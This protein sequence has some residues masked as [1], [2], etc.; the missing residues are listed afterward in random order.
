VRTP[1]SPVRERERGR[2]RDKE[3]EE[4]RERESEKEGKRERERER[5]RICPKLLFLFLNGMTGAL[6]PFSYLV[7]NIIIASTSIRWFQDN[8]GFLNICFCFFVQTVNC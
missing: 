4:G 8:F 2:E 3:R 7:H 5:C 6:A 1:S